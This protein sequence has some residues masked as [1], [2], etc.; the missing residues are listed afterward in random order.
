MN[1]TDEKCK[2]FLVHFA[3]GNG[4]SFNFLKDH[5]P[6]FEFLP[7]ELPGRGKRMNESLL[8]DFQEAARDIFGQIRRLA[9]TS[10]FVI[11]GHSMGAYLA[12]KVTSMLE[13][14]GLMPLS[15]IVSGNAGPG[16]G[17]DKKRHL[18]KGQMFKDELKDIVGMPEEKLSYVELFNSFE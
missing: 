12:L 11:Y 6:E 14:A 5:L 1:C 10:R 2:I 3:G 8:T 16:I 18:M 13:D 17:D 9:G 4:Y 7:L 15:I